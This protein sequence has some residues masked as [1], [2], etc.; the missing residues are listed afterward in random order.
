MMRILLVPALLLLTACGF[1]GGT[2]E[3][4][5][6]VEVDRPAQQVA[7]DLAVLDADVQSDISLSRTQVFRSEEGP[8]ALNFRLVAPKENEH[9]FSQPEA[10]FKFRLEALEGGRTRIAVTLDVPA[11]KVDD[12]GKKKVLSEAKVTTQL[13][14]AL[15]KYAAAVKGGG[16]TATA[17]AEID[18][19]FVAVALG[20]D[21]TSMEN[22][23][24]SRYGA[25]DL[26]DLAE[27]SDAYD[28]S[29]AGG[30]YG[31][32][33]EYGEPTDTTVPAYE[34]AYEGDGGWGKQ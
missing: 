9:Q 10:N 14:S 31:V 6:A 29:D 13:R 11:V 27:A 19:L 21:K 26:A 3:T 8:Y 16:E 18:F 34:T 1:G 23:A 24:T 15:E 5:F 32:E 25:A 12:A 7:T 28:S 20:M 17:V 22:L 4:G 30:Y 2:G 33:P